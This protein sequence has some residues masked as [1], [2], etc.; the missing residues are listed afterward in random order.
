MSVRAPFTALCASYIARVL[1]ESI[2]LAGL[3]Y[4]TKSFL[5]TRATSAIEGKKESEIVRKFGPRK[6]LVLSVL[7]SLCALSGKTRVL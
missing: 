3:G 6:H 1:D 4:T 7:C 2:S 5:A